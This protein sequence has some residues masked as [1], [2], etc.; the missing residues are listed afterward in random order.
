VSPHLPQYCLKNKNLIN[1]TTLQEE[2]EQSKK[3]DTK[4]TRNKVFLNIYFVCV[5]FS[6]TVPI[7]RERSHILHQFRISRYECRNSVYA[8]YN[9]PLFAAG[10]TRLHEHWTPPPRIPP[11]PHGWPPT[12]KSPSTWSHV[13]ACTWPHADRVR[14]R[15]RTEVDMDPQPWLYLS[16]CFESALT[17]RGSGS[18]FSNECG[19]IRIRI[20]HV[21]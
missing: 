8:S 15:I 9:L 1:S 12:C 10:K 18:S 21:R 13:P 3:Y 14:V 16:Q 2:R 20:L 5:W 19:S 17:L 7:T 6:Y 4:G 11:A